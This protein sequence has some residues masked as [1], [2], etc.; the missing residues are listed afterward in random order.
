MPFLQL[1]WKN[2]WPEILEKGK[3]M[4]TVLSKTEWQKKY[5]VTDVNP[6]TGNFTYTDKFN[7]NKLDSR[8]MFLRNPSDFYKFTDG[9]LE[10][11]AKAVNISQPES[12]SAIFVRQQHNTF[13]A[14]TELT[15]NPSDEHQLA[16]L[17]L[18]QNEEYNFVFGKTMREGKSVVTLKRAERTNITVASATLD[19]SE[20]QQPLRLKVEGDGRYYNFYYAA[21]DGAWKLLASGVDAVNLSTHQSGGFIGACIG[22]Y[23]TLSN[24]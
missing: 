15:F 13:T 5:N 11:N 7:G 14:E 23:A 12:P 16:G 4:P 6:T 19:N 17:V 24:K 21:G 20:S 22:L 18:L 10:I 9:G 8:W 3:A 2:G 1:S